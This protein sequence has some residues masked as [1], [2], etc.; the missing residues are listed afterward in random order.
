MT[1]KKLGIV[2]MGRI[3][4]ATARRARQGFGMRIYCY[5]R[6]PVPQAVLDELQAQPFS[7]LDELA[8]HVDFLS[9][10]CPATPD[11]RHLIDARRLALMQ[12]TACLINASRGALVNERAL[13]DALSTGRLAG[14]GL[15]VYE[16]E[17]KVYDPLLRLENVVLLPHMGSSTVETRHAMG[18]RVVEN[19]ERFFAG[20]EPPDICA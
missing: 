8:A 4:R 13:A 15:D 18:M 11:T 14:A 1:G 3:G 5:N 10:H 2:G 20:G 9:L 17:P 12:P 7:N 6:S 16:A 19:L